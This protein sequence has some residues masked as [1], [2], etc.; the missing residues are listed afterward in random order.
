MCCG[1]EEEFVPLHPETKKRQGRT[2]Q[3]YFS[4]YL[5][6]SFIDAGRIEKKNNKNLLGW[7]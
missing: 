3:K 2:E 5:I 6:V 1:N 7:P 4:A